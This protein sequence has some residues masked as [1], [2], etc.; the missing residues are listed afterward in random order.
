MAKNTKTF[1]FIPGCTNVKFRT[2][3]RTFLSLMAHEDDSVC[4][5]AGPSTS[6]GN[7]RVPP[8]IPPD[9]LFLDFSGTGESADLS[10]SSPL[11]SGYAPV[12]LDATATN[13]ANTTI[14]EL[15]KY[16]QSKGR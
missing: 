9:K 4:L 16:T 1:A 12:P 7:D 6:R 11:I 13:L 14:P 5:C 15:G 2:F 3:K 8:V 10:L